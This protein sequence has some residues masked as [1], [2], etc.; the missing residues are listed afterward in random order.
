ML[1]HSLQGTDPPCQLDAASAR[2]A[3]QQKCISGNHMSVPLPRLFVKT[4]CP[5]CIDVIDYL[6]AHGIGY[7]KITVSGN[8][9]AMAEMQK[10]SGQTKAPTMDWDGEILADFGVEE[11]VEFLARK[12]QE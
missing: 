6:D 1:V 8:G 5:W 12:N 11:L 7:E 4:G 2:L 3:I 10:L 9:E